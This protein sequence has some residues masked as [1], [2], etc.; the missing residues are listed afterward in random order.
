[1]QVRHLVLC[2]ISALAWNPYFLWAARDRGLSVL[3]LES[4][5][6]SYRESPLVRELEESGNLRWV[7]P[8]HQ[9]QL[10]QIVADWSATHTV[11]ICGLREDWVEAAA[12]L[13]EGLG[14]PSPG[15]WAARAC[16]D[17]SVQ[18]VLLREWSPRFQIVPAG[19]NRCADDRDTY[20]AVVK[21]VGRTGSSGVTEVSD[22]RDMAIAL[23]R[24]GSSE[25]ALIEE[26]VYGPE[27]SVESMVQRG[28]VVFSGITVK[29][30]VEGTAHAFAEV[31]HTV[32]PGQVHEREDELRACNTGVL[33]ALRVRDG[34][35]HGEYRITPDGIRVMEVNCRTAGGNIPTLYNLATGQLFEDAIIDIA[36]GVEVR[37]PQPVRWAREGYLANPAG[38]LASV[39]TDWPDVDQVWIKNGQTLRRL[40]LPVKQHEP[41]TVRSLMVGKSKGDAIGPIRSNGDRVASYVIDGPDLKAIESLERSFRAATRIVTEGS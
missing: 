11:G 27:Y 15:L 19:A 5:Q 33:H 16:R 26:R 24:L 30:T 21:P 1:V 13:A 32:G 40:D 12:W 39:E 17:K 2:G 31:S 29:A 36:L 9:A 4:P 34:V 6:S 41:A 14:A 38:V 18:R 7:E 3:G 23:G 8:E 35:V 37:Y 20:A 10:L 22:R 25:T 28:E